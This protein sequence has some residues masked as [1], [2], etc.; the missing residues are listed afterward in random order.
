MQNINTTLRRRIISAPR[1][2]RARAYTF[3]V[4][5][6]CAAAAVLILTCVQ[7]ARA[8]SPQL[9]GARYIIETR[10][11]ATFYVGR[12]GKFNLVLLDQ[13][14]NRLNAPAAL[15]TTVTVTTLDSLEEAKASLGARR[16]EATRRRVITLARGQNSAQLTFTHRMGEQ[17]EVVHLLSNQP[18]RLNIFAESE[19]VATGETTVVVLDKKPPTAAALP[20]AVFTHAPWRIVPASLQDEGMGNYKLDLVPSRRD[21]Q[22]QT[23]GGEQV[24]YFRVALLST[25]DNGDHEAPQDIRVILRVEEGNA[26]FVG[27]DTL[28]IR[29]DEAITSEKAE[30]RTRGGVIKVN[31][32]TATRINNARVI[33]V[34]RSYEL[35]PGI[36]STHLVITR[37][38]ESAYANGLDEIVLKV[39]AIQDKR[40]ITPDRKSVV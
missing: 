7:A 16:P 20:A 27:P 18:G 8:R 10:E 35:K 14:G 40:A 37:E 11:T 9:E 24:V 13:N 34:S 17:D 26:R 3:A 38:R 29:K 30:L 31:A 2:R 33:P 25:R 36:H 39:A 6:A 12:R 19:N 15:N 21:P 22:P 1:S 28:T 23:S 5:A 4:A 32:S